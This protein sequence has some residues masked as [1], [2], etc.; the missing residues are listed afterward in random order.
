VLLSASP[1]VDAR[2]VERLVHAAFGATIPLRF[3]AVD[4][5]GSEPQ[6][7]RATANGQLV[8]ARA[9][10]LREAGGFAL[11][12]GHMTDDVALAR[13]LA[14]RGWRV[15]GAD[16]AALA[17]V[18][19][20]AG[21]RAT[22]RGLARSVSGGDV[23][24]RGWIAADLLVLWVAQA[25]PW[26]RLATRHADRLDGLLLA[27]RAAVLAR[28]ARGYRAGGLRDPF[29]WS[30]VLDVPVVV[31]FTRAVLRPDRGWRGRVYD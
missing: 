9:R 15:A 2:G 19:P 17:D 8:C 20:Y 29:W 27:G 10:P 1:A 3:G 4:G 18:R 26:L 12:A 13:A 23:T 24:G 16:A 31:A 22:W 25:L 28:T 30:W 6:P 21:A 14:G 7:S 5:R 11:A